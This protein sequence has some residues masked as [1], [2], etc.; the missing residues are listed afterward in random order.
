MSLLQFKLITPERIVFEKKVSQVTLPTMDGE[1]SIL[2]SHI[3]LVAELVPGVAMLREHNHSEDV[4]VSGGFIQVDKEGNVTV[5]ADTAERGEDLNLRDIE[6]AKARAEQ[7]M[8]ESARGNDE[9]FARAAAEL[10]R[11][12]ARYRVARKYKAVKSQRSQ[13]PLPDSEL[14][15]DTGPV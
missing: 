9:A 14:T 5:L 6:E 4:A 3:P 2:P 8:R 13:E 15:D 11:E 10:E 1:I 7:V 12:L